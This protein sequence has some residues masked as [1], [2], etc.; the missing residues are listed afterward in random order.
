[1]RVRAEEF[2]ADRR[3]G[4][5]S[6]RGIWSDGDVIY[7]ADANDDKVYSYNMPDASD[8]RLVTLALSRTAFG[9]F[10]PLR[11]DYV[12]ATLP[13]GGIATLTVAAAQDGASVRVEPAD[14][15]GDPANGH[16]VRL[17]PGLEIRVTVT[18][19]D[20]SRM[21]VYRLR[22]EGR[23]PD[24]ITLDLRAG[25]DLVV[26]PVGAATTAA[27]L[28]GGTDV[29]IVWQ[30]NRATRAWDRS[31]L[32][33]LGSGGFPIAG[34]DVLW[35]VSPVEQTLPVAGTPPPA[36]PI[37]GPITLTLRAGGDLVPV[38]AGTPTTAADLFGGTDVTI[39][40]QYNRA[41]RAWDRSYLPAL[42][43]GGFPIAGGDVL[44]V[45]APRALTVTEG[46]PVGDAV[47]GRVYFGGGEVTLPEGAVV[48]VRLLDIS[49]ADAPSTTIGEQIIRD[50]RGLPLAF[51][52]GYDPAAI[53]EGYEYSLQATVRHAGRL[54]YINDTVHPVL[55]RGAP[56]NSDIAVIRVQ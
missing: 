55:T 24:P 53:M 3:A 44:W 56:R 50:A 36:V 17:L 1:M 22:I 9:A 18:S 34:G 42:G 21:R 43:S 49:L 19:P 2:A 47:S 6:P 16:H 27:D 20:G 46:A 26:V 4:N 15:D 31:Y 12:S 39:V 48:T 14:H 32:P 54:L 41:T 10:S 11:Y 52:V 40:W 35:V 37:A 38:P 45:V 28:F 13:D 23:E 33:A 25:G 5:N 8:A 51:R 29:T 7:V 30:Y